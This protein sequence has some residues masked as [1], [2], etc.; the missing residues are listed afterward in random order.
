MN[1]F[2]VCDAHIKIGFTKLKTTNFTNNFNS[3]LTKT[4]TK[5][6]TIQSFQIFGRLHLF[7]PVAV[8]YEISSYKVET[9][10][11]KNIILY[12]LTD[13]S[14]KECKFCGQVVASHS[15]AVQHINIFEAGANI[16]QHAAMLTLF[17]RHVS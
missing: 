16:S 9:S 17:I 10:V 8:I 3:E 11:C 12:R 14:V 1:I 5:I 4:P 13:E 6:K 2:T 7:L 15:G